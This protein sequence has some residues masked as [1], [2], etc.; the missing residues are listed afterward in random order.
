MIYDYTSSCLFQV[1][2]E[3]VCGTRHSRR[4]QHRRQRAHGQVLLGQGVG[5]P[6]QPLGKQPGQI[7]TMKIRSYNH[8]EKFIYFEFHV[9][10][11]YNVLNY[12]LKPLIGCIRC[13]LLSL[14]LD[15]FLRHV[16]RPCDTL[17]F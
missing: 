7:H 10:F 14:A 13:I 3:G 11:S 5:G 1:F 17:H 4:A 2:D 9:A 8:N 6:Q 15:H 12:R 16:L